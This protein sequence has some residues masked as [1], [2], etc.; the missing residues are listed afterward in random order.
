MQRKME[1]S[2][3]KYSFSYCGK[4]D[5][6]CMRSVN[7]DR[8]MLR[9]EA[10]LFG[11]SDGMGGLLFGEEAATYVVEA[12]PLLID[13][14]KSEL[15]G[16]EQSYEKV[17]TKAIRLASDCLYLKGNDSN[18][19]EFGATVVCLWLHGSSASLCWMGDSRMYL[20]R[21]TFGQAVR[22]TE[23]MNIAGLLLDAGE[24]SEDT[25]EVHPG[26]STLTAFVGM[27]IPADLRSKT[28][29]LEPGDILLMSSD[30]LHGMV[31]DKEITEV[32]RSSDDVEAVCERLVELANENGGR[33]NISALVISIDSKLSQ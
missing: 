31:S 1:T 5:I 13:S 28:I 30:G 33:D 12:L 29:E 20:L 25:A 16:S 14:L 23:D 9:P 15:D 2:D 18:C 26:R 4:S 19:I 10:G 22:Q 32:L 21:S 8:I 7:Q 6:G 3:F 17:L 11:V 24:I 27:Q